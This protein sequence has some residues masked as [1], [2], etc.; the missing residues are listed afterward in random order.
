MDNDKKDKKDKRD[1]EKQYGAFYTPPECVDIIL[2]ALPSEVWCDPDRLWLEPSCG[3]GNFVW[4]IYCRLMQGLAMAIPTDCDRH[5]H[6]LGKML[7]MVDID[8]DSVAFCVRRFS[9]LFPEGV[10]VNLNIYCGDIL[11]FT[12][13][14]FFP[15]SNQNL[16]LNPVF[17][18]IVG[19][20]PFCVEGA[21]SLGKNKLYERIVEWSLTVLSPH[22]ILAYVVPDTLFGGSSSR[23]Y[24]KMLDP[25]YFIPCI[26][27]H[28]GEERSRFFP[29]VQ[30]PTCW[31]VL[32]VQSQSQSQSKQTRIRNHR[33]E[34]FE[35]SLSD[36][37]LNPVRD[38]CLE[39]EI[40]VSKYISLDKNRSVYNRGYSLPTYANNSTNTSTTKADTK[41]VPIIYMLDKDKDFNVLVNLDSD[42]DMKLVR[43]MGV[44]KIVIFAASSKLSWRCDDTGEYGVGP[45][46]FYIPCSF[47][48]DTDDTDDTNNT[49]INQMQDIVSFFSSADCV[50]LVMATKTTRQFIKISLIRH[51]NLDVI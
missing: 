32:V 7:Y 28:S 21:S 18:V 1:K 49:S 39:T 51:L 11:D 17:D 3:T 19:N 42:A 37:P 20:P 44:P 45:N 5:M 23:A 33:S 48:D 10:N 50:R 34:T 9:S 22:G 2:D 30:Q 36:R 4:Q 41:L 47:R 29:G 13:S 16:N 8:P 35:I 15:C 26:T 6:I 31:F 38:W 25:M 27:F 24:C 14:V 43:G 12:M 46:T 40:L